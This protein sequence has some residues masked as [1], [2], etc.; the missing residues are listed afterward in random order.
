M[1]TNMNNLL[2]FQ[3][4]ILS[5]SQTWIANNQIKKCVW[6]WRQQIMWEKKKKKN[7]ITQNK[8]WLYSKDVFYCEAILH[9]T[10][11]LDVSYFLNLQPI[12]VLACCVQGGLYMS[13]QH[14]SRHNTYILKIRDSTLCNILIRIKSNLYIH[15]YFYYFT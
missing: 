2:H 7:L 1:Q 6:I 9:E 12:T 5:F 14:R 10:W 13:V 4:H 8:S 11:A 3:L 15:V